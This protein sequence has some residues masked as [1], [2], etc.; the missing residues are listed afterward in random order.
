MEN[1]ASVNVDKTKKIPW[2]IFAGILAMICSFLTVGIIAGAV[3]VISGIGKEYSIISG[4]GEWWM[5][6]L[7]VAEA[8]VVAGMVVCIIFYVKNALRHK[9]EA[10]ENI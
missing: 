1:D 5:I 4:F 6:L 2:G 9:G 8:V 10:N 3:L 7:Y